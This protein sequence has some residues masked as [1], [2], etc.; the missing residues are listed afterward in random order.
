MK[1][2]KE[3]MKKMATKDSLGTRVSWFLFKYRITPQTTTG[4][5]PAELLLERKPRA[6][7]D[8][9]HPDIREKVQ[10]G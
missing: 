2:F 3:G 9:I 5:A 10:N 6:R 7:L 4:I 8:L 1:S